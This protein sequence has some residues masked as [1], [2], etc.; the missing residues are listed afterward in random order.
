MFDE[1]DDRVQD[2]DR[3][4]HGG[5]GCRE[6]ECECD[7]DDDYDDDDDEAEL[8]NYDEEIDSSKPYVKLVGNDG[9]AFAIMGACQRAAREAKW[10]REEIEAVLAEM[11]S[12]D[13]DHLLATAIKYFDV[14]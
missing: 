14:H 13:Y 2:D 8:D 5:C 9:N 11:Q 4:C 6:D 12:G 1:E 3:I 7:W 10:T